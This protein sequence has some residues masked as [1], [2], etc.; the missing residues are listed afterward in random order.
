MFID[1]QLLLLPSPASAR[2]RSVLVSACWRPARWC[3]TGL[4]IALA[5]ACRAPATDGIP[6]GAVDQQ[7]EPAEI[8]NGLQ[9]G[10][11]SEVQP[12]GQPKL[13]IHFRNASSTPFD[14][15]EMGPLF[16]EIQVE[17]GRWRTI[18]HPRWGSLEIDTMFTFAPGHDESETEP[19]SAFAELGPGTYRVRV[20]MVFDRGMSTRY[21]S[22][23]LWTGAI[24]SNTVEIFV[25]EP[26]LLDRAE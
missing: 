25:P 9:L 24:R 23:H 8:V 5:N 11:S 3:V 6:A 15:V 4:V 2:P 18:Q 1:R 19:V 7:A 26:A 13:I 22:D 17:Q 10:L 21:S 14:I 12:D 16:L 20:S